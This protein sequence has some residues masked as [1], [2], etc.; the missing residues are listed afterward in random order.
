MKP[1]VTSSPPEILL[2]FLRDAKNLV[3]ATHINPEGDALGSTLAL[4][5]ALERLN[6]HTLLFDRD[7]VPEFYRYL[8]GVERFRNLDFNSLLKDFQASHGSIDAIILLDCNTPERADIEIPEGI[9]LVIIDHHEIPGGTKS[10]PEPLIWIDPTA[11]ATGMMVYK[12][13]KALGVE[14]DYE[15]ALNLYTAIA[16]D[17]GTFRYSNT[18]S[19]VLQVASELLQLGVRPERVSE[20][21][22]DNW[23][24]NRFRL[25]INSLSTL[26]VDDSVGG[27][28]TVAIIY[29]DEG[30]F[31]ETG[32]S[33]EDTEN[34]SSF[35]RMIKDVKVSVFLRQIGPSKWKASLRSKGLINVAS[36]ARRFG[37]GGHRNA[38][39]FFID[40]ELEDIKRR[41]K[42]AINE[43]AR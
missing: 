19:E 28:V 26:E 24:I 1:T 32:T 40:G 25:L 22:Y 11:P 4:S 39:G 21:L 2:D 37:G 10:G 38:A 16:V 29:V 33:E 36:V 18:S 23:S 27:E 34:F 7:R 12:L 43:M 31:K 3:L 15:M 35:P 42:E 6:K 20:A 17:T 5:M 41:I 8:P 9:S 14:L 30:M 13:I